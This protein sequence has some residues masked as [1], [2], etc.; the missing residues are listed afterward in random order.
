MQ[1][2]IRANGNANTRR[3]Y[4]SGWNG[5][6]R[7]LDE[8]GVHEDRITEGDIADYLRK[9]L[10]EDGVSAATVA[11]D[12]AAIGNHLKYGPLNKL[13]LSP[14]VTNTMR[15]CMNRAA[16]SKPKQHI[17]TELMRAIYE[18]L[19]T[20]ADWLKKR[21]AAMMLTMMAGM[22]RQSEAAHL[23]VDDT[24]IMPAQED[25]AAAAA[26]AS[27]AGIEPQGAFV[28]LL[29]RNSKTDQAGRG[30]YVILA[31]NNADPAL[32][33]V[34]RIL[35]YLRARTAA[36]VQ[37]AFLF[38][39]NDGN[40][41]STSTPCGIV[42]RAVAAA[43][44][45]AADVDGVHEKWGAPETYGSHSLRRGGVT[46]AR[47]NGVDML[48]IQR[49][50]RWKSLAVLGYVGPTLTQQL[51]VTQNMFS[52]AGSRSAPVTPVKAKKVSVDEPLAKAD[53]NGSYAHETATQ[54]ANR[55]A[56]I[57][58]GNWWLKPALGT[59]PAASVIGASDA[60]S[61]HSGL[62]L[63][64]TTP[65]AQGGGTAPVVTTASVAATAPMIRTSPAGGEGKLC[66]RRVRRRGLAAPAAC[67]S[68]G[69]DAEDEQPTTAEQDDEALLE[70]LQMEEWQQGYG[71][72]APAR[73]AATT[74]R[75]ITRQAERDAARAALEAV[76]ASAA[77]R[78]GSSKRGQKRK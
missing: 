32:C 62:A 6:K 75:R 12:R 4:D 33:P 7:Y 68:D 60:V 78:R 56:A 5:F 76:A 66:G 31:A 20:N 47:R 36:G 14:L 3:S 49:H 70:A 53:A 61:P 38:P 23:R 72:D 64:Q 13:H 24:E 77:A 1:A 18:I 54:R 74:H 55:L 59:M 51:Q 50:G 10:E 2:W 8:E 48:D 58:A 42:Q 39:K 9:R 67:G 29:V 26:A 15:I 37:S 22:L 43:N 30:A 11:G 44:Q 21:D 25:A 45:Q 46:E 34:R 28:R 65:I 19:P 57:R 17:S 16:Q 63:Q 71:E 35:D 41:M 27:G 69:D 52:T 40:Q 73:C